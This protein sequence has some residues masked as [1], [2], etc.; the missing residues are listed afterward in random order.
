M[1]FEYYLVIP[2]DLHTVY[3]PS[4]TFSW[5]T[6]FF[7]HR[8]IVSFKSFRWT[9]P[10]TMCQFTSSLIRAQELRWNVCRQPQRLLY[11]V[12]LPLPSGLQM[13]RGT[14]FFLLTKSLLKSCKVCKAGGGDSLADIEIE[15]TL[16]TVAT[17]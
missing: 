8:Y 13:T 17:L 5:P 1:F 2:P 7:E 10:K 16:V 11:P 12:L 3:I 4:Q 9:Y 14:T 15:E 6:T